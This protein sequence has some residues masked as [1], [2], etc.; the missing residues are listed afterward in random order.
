MKI[1]CEY[2]EEVLVSFLIDEEE[3]LNGEDRPII[4][5]SILKKIEL[6]DLPYDVEIEICESK[7]DNHIVVD[8]PA[9]F[10]RIGE[11]KFYVRYEEVIPRKYWDGPIG[12]KLYMET[13][14]NIVQERFK[15]IG[16]VSL[17]Y[18]EDEGNYIS[19]YYCCEMEPDSVEILLN[20]I[21]QLYEEVDGATEITLGLPFPKIKECE[22]E[23]EFTIRILLPLFRKLGFV[24]V[25]YNHGN[26]EFG[27][28]ITF[29]R[30]TEFD[31]YEYYGVQVKYG[32]VSG[33]AHGEI[34]ELII[35]AKDAFSMPY[36]DV[37]SRN[38]VFVSKVIIAVSGKYTQNAVEK[39]IEGIHD[40]PLK[41]NIIFLDREKIESLMSKY[42]RF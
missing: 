22:K 4:P 24:N 25:K 18:Y 8:A 14:R 27:K 16:D 1:H 39:I 3:Y 15:E 41:N 40:Y 6:D 5:V 42:I 35:Q 11:K 33:G 9:Y 17:E 38:K 32:D 10:K 19:L 28:D 36:Y 20:D 26:R 21:K 31:D 13:K 37:Y 12:L 29:A 34:N 2:E 30:R 23:S 7:N